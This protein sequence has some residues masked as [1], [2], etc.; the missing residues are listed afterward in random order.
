MVGDENWRK[1][2]RLW[3]EGGTRGMPHKQT[4]SKREPRCVRCSIPLGPHEA[5]R[6]LTKKVRSRDDCL[7]Q[8]QSEIEEVSSGGR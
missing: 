6:K 3:L 1:L 8:V 4:T 7:E 5:E 2:L